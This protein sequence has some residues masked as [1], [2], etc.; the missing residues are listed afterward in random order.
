MLF[1]QLKKLN[2][3]LKRGLR[4]HVQY[5]SDSGEIQ[6]PAGLLNHRTWGPTPE[7]LTWLVWSW[8]WE[9][10][11]LTSSQEALVLLIHFE[12]H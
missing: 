1:K 2:T 8:T 3:K 11:F 5:S 10:A 6:A 7:F 4:D 12:N 9:S